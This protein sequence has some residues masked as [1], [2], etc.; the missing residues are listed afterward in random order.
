MDRKVYVQVTG[1]IFLLVAILH[2]AR[3]VFSWE[4][5]IGGFVMPMWVSFV[6]ILVAGYLAYSAL[7]LH[8]R[9]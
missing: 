3:A 7:E 9:G 8:R 5:A 1:I 4:A 2:A 6:A